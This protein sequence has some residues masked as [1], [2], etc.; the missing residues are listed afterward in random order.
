MSALTTPDPHFDGETY[1]PKRDHARLTSQLERV[2]SI[3][4]DG[5]KR[6]IREIY[7]LAQALREDGGADSESGLTARIRDLRKPKFGG[8]IVKRESKGGGLH[9]YWIEF[10]PREVTQDSLFKGG[11]GS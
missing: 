2:R 1:E 7:D 8:H 6:T 9:V 11:E 5:R 10:P 3:M 4:L